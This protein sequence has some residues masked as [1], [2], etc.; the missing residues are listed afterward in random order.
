[1]G[2]PERTTLLC[3]T[4]MEEESFYISRQ[5]NSKIILHQIF[6]FS[7]LRISSIE[8]TRTPSL[9]RDATSTQELTPHSSRDPW[10][11]SFTI[12]YWRP[13]PMCN[14][15]C[16]ELCLL[17]NNDGKVDRVC[18]CPENFILG[19]EGKSCESNCTS[20]QF[21]CSHKLMCFPFWMRCDVQ[22]DCGDGKDEPESCPE[23]HCNPR[24]LQCVTLATVPTPP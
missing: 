20:S 5:H 10:M 1:M 21:F 23:F 15:E 8:V 24:E 2:M 13:T 4:W 17:T 11:L 14:G 16:Q 12:Q 18:G 6:A 3:P 19:S 7:V 22:D 9:S